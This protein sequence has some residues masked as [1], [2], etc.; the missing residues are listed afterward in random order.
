MTRELTTVGKVWLDILRSHRSMR[1]AEIAPEFASARYVA[2][3]TAYRLGYVERTGKARN[4]EYRVTPHCNVPPGLP[5]LDV[6]EA[7]T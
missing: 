6:L 7:T 3:H 5:L 2:L 1:T 4:F